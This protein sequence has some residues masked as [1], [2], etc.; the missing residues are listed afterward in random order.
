ML[1]GIDEI[2]WAFQFLARTGIALQEPMDC[3]AATQLMTLGSEFVVK[4]IFVLK[5][6]ATG[7]G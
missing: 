7:R 1:F 5:S 6:A 2:S 4:N 3:K